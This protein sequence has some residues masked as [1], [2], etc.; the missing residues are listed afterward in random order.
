M[1]DFEFDV[2]LLISLVEARPVLRDRTDDIYRDR[3]EKKRKSME[4]SLC[5]SSRRLENHRRCSKT[6]FFLSIAII[7]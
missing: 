4:R 3:N 7:Y 6:P 2:G 5:L 1:G